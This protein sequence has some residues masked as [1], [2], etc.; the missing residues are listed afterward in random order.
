M[1]AL[2]LSSNFLF[3]FSSVDSSNLLAFLA[4]IY[5][6]GGF[7]CDA[8]ILSLCDTRAR[9]KYTVYKFIVRFSD[10]WHGGVLIIPLNNTESK[11]NRKTLTRFHAFPLSRSRTT[12]TTIAMALSQNNNGGVV[13]VVCAD[14]SFP[15]WEKIG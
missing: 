7:V 4:S 6:A 3:F 9:C 11:P 8:C 13:C 15:Y 12:K 1:L 14:F 5:S 2:S 10:K